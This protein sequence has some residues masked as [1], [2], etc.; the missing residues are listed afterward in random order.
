MPLAP[1]MAR[2]SFFDDSGNSVPDDQ[3]VRPVGG[4]GAASGQRSRLDAEQCDGLTA[5]MG[6]PNDGRVGVAHRRPAFERFVV[7]VDDGGHH[8]ADVEGQLAV[9]VGDLGEDVADRGERTAVEVVREEC[10]RHGRPG[11][12]SAARRGKRSPGAT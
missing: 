4:H 9:R 6:V 1:L 7:L 11:R 10:A 8:G 2:A 5:E 12:S 3:L